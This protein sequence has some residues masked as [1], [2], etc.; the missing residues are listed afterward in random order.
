MRVY[1]ILKM[2]TD[3][4]LFAPL[5][6]GAGGYARLLIFSQPQAKDVPDFVD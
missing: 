3:A 6:T 4:E 2:V 1:I 5:P